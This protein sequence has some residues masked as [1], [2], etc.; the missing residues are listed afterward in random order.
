MWVYILKHVPNSVLWLLRFP[1]VGEP[2]L[3]ATAHQLGKLLMTLVCHYLFLSALDVI[4]IQIL[5]IFR[6]LTVFY[7]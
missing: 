6:N 3:Q 4:Q 1:A 7:S 2:N 5:Q